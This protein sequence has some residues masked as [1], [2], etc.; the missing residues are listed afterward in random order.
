MD[1]IFKYLKD[2]F[3]EDEVIDDFDNLN[4]NYNFKSEKYLNKNFIFQNINRMFLQNKFSE[5][6]NFEKNFS[7]TI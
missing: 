6:K 3:F 2:N 5:I 7:T 1:K 4:L